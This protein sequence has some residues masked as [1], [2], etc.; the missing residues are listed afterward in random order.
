MNTI[1]EKEDLVVLLGGVVIFR[2]VPNSIQYPF[3]KSFDSNQ[4]QRQRGTKII[5]MN[6]NSLVNEIS[7]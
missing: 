7:M 5:A 3:R 2:A 4:G 1:F 6:S